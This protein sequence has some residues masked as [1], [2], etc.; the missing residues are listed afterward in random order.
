MPVL[1]SMRHHAEFGRRNPHRL[2]KG[3][4][5]SPVSVIWSSG[6]RERK[7]FRMA[8]PQIKPEDTPPKPNFHGST[9]ANYG[10][11]KMDRASIVNLPIACSDYFI[12]RVNGKGVAD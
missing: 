6:P 11:A 3:G 7:R 5:F 9:D 1:C 4:A 10:D 2:I 12:C 8:R